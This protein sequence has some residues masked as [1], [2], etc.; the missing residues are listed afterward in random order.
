MFVWQA[1]YIPPGADRLD[2]ALLLIPVSAGYFVAVVRSAI[3]NQSIN[4]TVTLVNMNYVVIVLSV[5]LFF[6]GALLF[7]VFSYPAVVVQ[8]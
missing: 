7:F 5:T 4:E 6:C 3:Q 1:R 8:R 2:L